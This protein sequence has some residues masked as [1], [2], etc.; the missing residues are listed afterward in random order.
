MWYGELESKGLGLLYHGDTRVLVRRSNGEV[1]F[2]VS[3][4]HKV[5]HVRSVAV[6]HNL[7]KSRY[8]L[9]A[10]FMQELYFYK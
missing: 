6:A 3:I 2:D 7:Q 8:V 4:I 5:L 9:M 10:N 1:A